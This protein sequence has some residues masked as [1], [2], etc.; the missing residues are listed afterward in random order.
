[1]VR[2]AAVIALAFALGTGGCLRARGTPE[3][4]VV[5]KF[6]LEGVRSV[7]AD[8]LKERLAT[9]ASGRWRW[10]EPKRLDPDALA[11]DRRRVEAY[12]RARGYYEA[13]ADVEVVRPGAD[14][15]T[16]VMRVTEG[17]PVRVTKLTVNGLAEAPEARARVGALPLR[18]GDVFTEG[19]YD[20]SRAALAAALASTGWATAEVTQRA[21]ILPEAAA[22]EVTYDVDAGRRWKFGAVS[23]AA[24]AQLP[25]GKILDQVHAV[26][27]PGDWWDETKLA[28]AQVRVFQ[29]G[30]FGGVRVQRLRRVDEQRGTIGVEVLI[31]RAPF[32]TVRAGPGLGVQA[33]RWD[34]HVLTGWQDRNFYGDLRRLGVE[35]RLGYAWLP[36]PWGA[37]K[38]GTV[39][40]VSTEFGQPGAFTRW[41]DASARLELEKGIEQAFDFYSERL[42]LSLPLRLR[43]RWKLT[44]SYNLEVYDLS[45]YGVEVVPGRTASS[46]A[47]EN[48]RGSVCLLTYLEQ[49]IAWDGRDDPL[50]T[51]RGLYVGVSVQEAF[52]VAGYGYRYLRFFPEA[53]W[54]R[55]LS[56]RTVLALRG[57]VGALVPLFETGAPPVIAR[58]QAGGPLSMRGYYNRRL[59][60]MERQ[61]N[62]WVPVGGNGLADGSAE[63]RFALTGALGAAA[64]LDAG[65]ISDASSIPSA[66]QEA[67]SPGALQYAAG[68]GLRYRTP[69]GPLRVDVAARLPDRW[70]TDLSAFPAVPF[71]RWPDG[72]LHREP[73]VA[74]HISI[75]EAF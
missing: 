28:E 50:N 18:V 55:P 23:L 38:A 1:M 44:P 67:L 16:V 56:E 17:R 9:Q 24:G 36:N 66:W 52:N 68:L 32:R 8:A 29:L 62:D 57:R 6:R 51:R 53:R 70:S 12:Y 46:A 20:A 73:I 2:S 31:Q 42:K 48:C 4:P 74:V 37:T 45:N 7:D 75:G 54:F 61:G 71:T 25:R 64:F 21:V 33:I 49:T 14:R 35:G 39:G 58:F 27:H 43:P 10:S 65:G 40:L 15:V 47:L 5:T 59:A 60:R 11:A 63:L 26:I 13:K 72:A 22:A 19:A 69:F 30:A 34:A 41:V 3:E